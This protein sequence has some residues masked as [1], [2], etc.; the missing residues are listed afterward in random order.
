MLRIEYEYD[1]KMMS[2]E[3]KAEIGLTIL[4]AISL[5]LSPLS[6]IRIPLVQLILTISFSMT[7][8]T[9]R[10][11]NR[12][13]TNSSINS[14]SSHSIPLP[15]PKPSHLSSAFTGT[16]NSEALR[17]Y[18]QAQKTGDSSS[19]FHS[20]N[21]TFSTPSSKIIT[22]KSSRA[23][24]LKDLYTDPDRDRDRLHGDESL[25]DKEANAFNSIV[26]DELVS[27]D[28][29]GPKTNKSV[30]QGW[31]RSTGAG[32]PSDNPFTNATLKGK[33]K[34]S[35]IENGKDIWAGAENELDSDE[36]EMEG[37]R[38]GR[39]DRF[40][41][42]AT[43]YGTAQDYPSPVK[44]GNLDYGQE[45]EEGEEVGERSF[46]DRDESTAT[47]R[48]PQLL[49][50]TNTTS[51]STPQQSNNH[52]TLTKQIFKSVSKSSSP[53]N[54][55]PSNSD[56]SYSND[57]IISS[58]IEDSPSPLDQVDFRR[59]TSL[60]SNTT[61]ERSRAPSLLSPTLKNDGFFKS[62]QVELASKGFDLERGLVVGDSSPSPT[63]SPEPESRSP[64][65]GE[66]LVSSDQGGDSRPDVT[67]RLNLNVAGP[68]PLRPKS[69]ALDLEKEIETLE[70]ACKE[71]DSQNGQEL[72][73]EPREGET[74]IIKEVNDASQSE[75]IESNQDANSQVESGSTEQPDSQL[76]I[77]TLNEPQTSP[78]IN[79]KTRPSSSIPNPNPISGKP[80]RA[81]Y[82]FIGEPSF[83]EL[84]LTA[85]QS[86]EILNEQL[87]GGWSLGLV[88][89]ERRIGESEE[90]GGIE[91][92]IKRGLVPRGW[93]CYIQDFTISPNVK[94]V[95]ETET[96]N[97]N[98]PTSSST[99]NIEEEG[100]D[101]LTPLSS[102]PISISNSNSIPFGFGNDNH[103]QQSQT[104]S[105][106]STK[107]RPIYQNQASYRPTSSGQNGTPDFS[108]PDPIAISLPSSNCS[109][110]MASALPARAVVGLDIT[111]TPDR[112]IERDH[113]IG[114]GIG[115]NERA[116]LALSVMQDRNS[117][118]SNATPKNSRFL[119]RNYERERKVS[120]TSI[121]ERDRKIS[122]TSSSERD[123]IGI[124]SSSSIGN[125]S[126]SDHSS[127]NDGNHSI[128][129]QN[130]NK[131]DTSINSSS[132][133]SSSFLSFPFSSRSVSNS[134][135][136][137]TGS[138]TNSTL[139]GTIG[140]G[141]WRSTLFG[142]KSLNRFSNF[143][144]SGV[145]DYVISN[146]F[147]PTINNNNNQ[148]IP[149][150]NSNSFNFSSLTRS[151]SDINSQLEEESSRLEMDSNCHFVQAGQNGPTWK[152]K[153]PNFFVAV[154]DPRKKSKMNGM[155]EYTVFAVSS[156]FPVAEESPSKKQNQVNENGEPITGDH[157]E[158]GGEGEGDHDSDSLPYDPTTPP[159]PQGPILTVD[160]RYSQFSWLY[161]ILKKNYAAL[162]L[163]PL[164]SK[165]YSGRFASEFIETRR[166][167]LEAWL[168]RIIRHPLLRYS[169][170]LLFF[171]SCQ[172]D[173]EF[174]KRQ[175]E[176]V[177]P[178]VIVNRGNG[179]GNQSGALDSKKL[180]GPPAFFANTFHP[181]FNVEIEEA[182]NE[183][184]EMERFSK[185][186]ERAVNGGNQGAV[187][188]TGGVMGCL[189]SSREGDAGE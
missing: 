99:L 7:T 70:S 58:P 61:T 100:I 184:K 158:D 149:N 133:A 50:S 130:L 181:E 34:E 102:P 24:A 135:A 52:Q 121:N 53:F 20:N 156:I 28:G 47:V 153:S 23:K 126:S 45:E 35:G 97:E 49:S 152:S 18:I 155:S 175:N 36:E 160:R 189:K 72:K 17:N 187:A 40:V 84:N 188:L 109:N 170:A 13:S 167:D 87:R 55:I 90:E 88:R 62:N 93:Y 162:I 129:S 118:A 111:G 166:S 91:I 54:S 141:G 180:E 32:A 6:P 110:Q 2:S 9:S 82:D 86:F 21:N 122:T 42:T 80:A 174:K 117:S 132:A 19:S 15:P 83:N 5:M 177:K 165:Q 38:R 26:R 183:V 41:S 113:E 131:N 73:S 138:T 4:S 51:S 64:N 60:M 76:S 178:L 176:F 139:N 124:N 31:L 98:N 74:E 179:N 161:E 185:L 137:S 163:P 120:T 44:E 143:V 68:P 101:S 1:M 33:G 75:K 94:A 128:D 154:H 127:L 69:V 29:F 103:P 79:P 8:M 171:L 95:N 66:A 30:V 146:N 27:I 107:S 172:D 140:N 112:V 116:K 114:S 150:S 108:D 164:P 25:N 56:L 78:Q 59:P 104:G 142:G 119:G 169:D 39:H 186:N 144:T 12:T 16:L 46:H 134:T 67:S 10:N 11:R 145:E 151:E 182:E 168:S 136:T 92:E 96:S 157:D 22:T 148:S 57:E 71:E 65:E 115:R 77:P 48:G 159:Y 37:L 147:D 43:S 105:G 81:L 106:S 125:I 63:P 14:N 89:I 3:D 123:R 85:G 173:L